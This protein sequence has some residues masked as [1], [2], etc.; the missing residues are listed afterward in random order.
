[1]VAPE[2]RR[3]I[4][5]LCFDRE[6]NLVVA[7]FKRTK[8]GGHSE[9]QALLYAAMVTEMT[10]EEAAHSHAR[11]LSTREQTPPHSAESAIL[12]FLEWEET[13]EDAFNQDVRIIPA[14]QDFSAELTGT[15]LWL[16]KRGLDITCTSTHERSIEIAAQQLKVNLNAQMA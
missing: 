5:L 13:D 8:R 6:F 7:E 16:L 14:S 2:S 3:R 11:Y 1:M 15:V 9:L 10:F 4:E 12:K